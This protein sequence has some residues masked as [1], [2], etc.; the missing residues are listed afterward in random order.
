METRR[1]ADI[2]NSGFPVGVLAAG[3]VLTSWGGYR[4]YIWRL[5]PLNYVKYSFRI[6]EN[7]GT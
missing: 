2:D 4:G 6:K 7:Y 3:Q 5:E 1:R